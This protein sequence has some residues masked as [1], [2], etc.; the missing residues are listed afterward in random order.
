MGEGEEEVARSE[1]LADSE[2]DFEWSRR[3]TKTKR[4]GTSMMRTK[5]G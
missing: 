3:E 5:M 2:G 1:G 4:C